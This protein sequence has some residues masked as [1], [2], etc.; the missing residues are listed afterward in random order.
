MQHRIWHDARKQRDRAVGIAQDFDRQQAEL[1]DRRTDQECAQGRRGGRATH[2]HGHRRQR[3][4]QHP[5]FT[6]PQRGGRRCCHPLAGQQHTGRQQRDR[7]DRCG[8][9][10][11]K[12]KEQGA[13]HD[14]T[15]A[16]ARLRLSEGVG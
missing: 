4:Q 16:V 9:D 11:G 12:H 3:D 14:G 5:D 15:P 8:D 10:G 13:R 7:A 6:H 2:Q 1:H